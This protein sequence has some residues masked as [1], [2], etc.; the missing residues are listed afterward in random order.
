MA[1]TS[2]WSHLIQLLVDSF[3][4]SLFCLNRSSMMSGILSVFFSAQHI[5][6]QMSK[7][8]CL[9]TNQSTSELKRSFLTIWFDDTKTKGGWNWLAHGY[10]AGKWMAQ[11]SWLP[12][13][14]HA[15][16]HHVCVA[17]VYPSTTK[18][19]DFHLVTLILLLFILINQAMGV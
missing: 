5:V 9:L 15:Y 19:T 6:E 13:H 4:G 7:C 8:M 17:Y 18:Q 14:T 11:V 2:T 10:R 12:T 3:I 16:W 1:L